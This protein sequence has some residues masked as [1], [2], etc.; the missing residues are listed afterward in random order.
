MQIFV[1]DPLEH[2][3][4]M[5]QPEHPQRVGERIPRHDGKI[6]VAPHQRT[7]PGVFELLDAPDLGD[8]LAITGKRLLGDG[9]H[10]LNVV[11]RA[12]GVEHNGFDGHWELMVGMSE[13]GCIQ[14]FER[15]R[16]HYGFAERRRP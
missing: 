12:I 11:K 10:R 7:Q 14:A 15:R 6:L 13:R 8:D 1:H 16:T 2:A 9:R 4:V 3:A 5:F